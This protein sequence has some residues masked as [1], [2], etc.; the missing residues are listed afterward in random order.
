MGVIL[1]V[2]FIFNV[3]QLFRRVFGAKGKMALSFVW[4][5]VYKNR[6]MISLAVLAI[7]FMKPLAGLVPSANKVPAA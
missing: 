6:N 2:P 5:V 1:C 3:R 7:R 4:V